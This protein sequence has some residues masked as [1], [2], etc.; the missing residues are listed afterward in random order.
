M[1]TKVKTEAILKYE[2]LSQKPGDREVGKEDLKLPTRKLRVKRPRVQGKTPVKDRSQ[3]NQNRKQA[4]KKS[5]S[6]QKQ[7]L[8]IPTDLVDF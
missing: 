3:Y 8:E 2:S 1:A 5:V 7:S 4:R 6:S